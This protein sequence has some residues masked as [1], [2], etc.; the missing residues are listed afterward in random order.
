MVFGCFDTVR[1]TGFGGVAFACGIENDD[2]LS[3]VF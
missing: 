1:G 3:P 2:A